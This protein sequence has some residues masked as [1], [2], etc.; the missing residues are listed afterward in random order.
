MVNRLRN[1]ISRKKISRFCQPQMA[2]KTRDWLQK[3]W[4]FWD[5][6]RWKIL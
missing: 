2:K 1:R 5:L 4:D 3:S 6:H